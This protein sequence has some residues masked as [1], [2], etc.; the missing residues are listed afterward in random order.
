MNPYLRR[1]VFILALATA[2]KTPVDAQGFNTIS[3]VFDRFSQVVVLPNGELLAAGSIGSSVGFQKAAATGQLLW[4]L[5]PTT[6]ASVPAAL[7]ATASNAAI[8]AWQTSQNQSL[9]IGLLTDG[10]L[11]WQITRPGLTAVQITAIDGNRYRVACRRLNAQEL[12]ESVLFTLTEN[13]VILSEQ[14]FQWPGADEQICGVSPLADGGCIMAGILRTGSDTDY[15]LRRSDEGG[16]V[17]WEKTLTKAGR[18]SA[19]RLIATRDG[20]FALVGYEQQT[21]PTAIQVLKF[22]DAGVTAWWRSFYL[23]GGFSFGLGLLI[24]PLARALVQG[25]DGHF[26]LPLIQIQNGDNYA[27]LLEL[28]EEGLFVRLSGIQTA[29]EANDI[30]VVSPHEVVICGA[31]DAP[32][33]GMLLRCD[34]FGQASPHRISGGIFTDLNGDC[35]YNGGETGAAEWVIA[36]GNSNGDRYLTRTDQ[37]GRFSLPVP[38]GQY[39]ILAFGPDGQTAF[40]STCPVPAIV[41]PQNTHTHVQTG[42]IGVQPQASCGILETDL[43]ATPA[44]ACETQT[45]SVKWANQGSAPLTDAVIKVAKDPSLTYES[46]TF[47]LG[48][49]DGDTLLFYLGATPQGASGAFTLRMKVSCDAAQGQAVCMKAWSED[50]FFYCIP[51]EPQ[52][53]GALITVKD[54]CDNG[55]TK[56]FR[57]RNQGAGNMQETLGYIIIEDQIILRTGSFQLPAS[58]DTLIQID[59][60]SNGQAWWMY[61]MQSDGIVTLDQPIA[62]LDNCD[63]PLDNDSLRLQLPENEADLYNSTHCSLVENGLPAAARLT[64][65][66]F[67]W[68]A[69]HRINP[70]QELEYLIHFAAT[71][72]DTVR[73][74]NVTVVL[75]TALLDPGTL[76]PGAVSHPAEWYVSKQGDVQFRLQGAWLAPQQE[77][78]VSFRIRPRAGLPVG[79]RIECFGQVR[80]DYSPLVQ[81]DTVFHT[82]GEALVSDVL[83]LP[84]RQ[85]AQVRAFP[86]PASRQVWLVLPAGVDHRGL[87]WSLNTSAG[88]ILAEQPWDGEA[89]IPLEGMPFGVYFVHLRNDAGWN[90]SV[91]IVRM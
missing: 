22:D 21:N 61:A 57:I 88:A 68:Q 31:S 77:G 3:P 42:Y 84:R 15:F 47:P 64:G 49:T 70:D 9:H 17:I 50:L 18:Q 81:T 87:R 30:A 65:Y 33:A 44:R 24:A 52:W 46:S 53:D 25:E 66:P 73:S 63:N 83:T 14:T 91:R 29:P 80:L 59:A 67:G 55:G 6:A 45:W 48:G 36:A 78:F 12:Y 56:G 41:L 51:P 54:S 90:A 10:Q 37:Q 4:Y 19:Y 27:S 8:V 76:R 5:Q 35:L 40:W 79:T 26:F 86:Q 72:T 75:N 34:A 23:D 16:A 2:W 13:G 71:G 82:I 39:E 85:P 32:Q 1:I 38:P 74:V 28:D 43:Q 20:Q 7:C 69:E 11:E 58:Q 62:F 89:A 60:G